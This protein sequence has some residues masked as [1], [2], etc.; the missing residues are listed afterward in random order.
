[1]KKNIKNNETT[2]SNVLTEIE[3]RFERHTNVLMEQ[4]KHEVKTVAEGHSSIIRKLEEHDKRFDRVDAKLTEHDKRF[5][6][7]ESELHSISM[8]VMDTGHEIKEHG[9]RI[10]R[11][12]EK[13]PA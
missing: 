8:A 12:E 2:N 5:I 9:K 1:M 6:K 13:S 3:K 7:V 4:V 10:K 11:I